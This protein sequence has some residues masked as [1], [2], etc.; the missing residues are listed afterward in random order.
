[1]AQP[2]II[3]NEVINLQQ[4][5]VP[6]ASIKHGLT[7]MSSERWIVCVEPS[8]V[9]LIDL[10]N[11]F[12]VTRRPIQ[13]EA[14]IMNPVSNILALRSGT[15]L[16]IFNLD[17]K[18]K[19]KS[20]TMPEP[21]VFW[22]WTSESNLA[23]VTAGSVY[24]WALDGSSAPVKMFDRHASIGAT[25]QIIN[26]QTSPDNK[27]LLLGGISARA[28]GGVNGNMQLYSLEK[29]VSQPPGSCW[30]FCGD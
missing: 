21:V 22:R 29:K 9:S 28:G 1:M 7:S 30:V 23:L 14:A 17:A 4:L 27:W 10:S 8:Q 26:Y 19:V 6:E 24:H 5:G 3:Y 13:A 2:P 20:H 15:T 16:Q 11:N 18:A 25:S 12:Q